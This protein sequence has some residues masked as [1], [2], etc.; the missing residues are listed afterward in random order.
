MIVD[1]EAKKKILKSLPKFYLWVGG[2]FDFDEPAFC[3]F[4]NAMPE[5]NTLIYNP[6]VDDPKKLKYI[7]VPCE[8]GWLTFV[9]EA[10]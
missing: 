9:R 1:K 3:E 2:A 4:I 5:E 7:N 10:E 6:S 8:G